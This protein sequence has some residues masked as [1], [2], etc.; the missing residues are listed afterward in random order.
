MIYV[1]NKQMRD[2]QFVH[3]WCLPKKPF[4]CYNGP[5]FSTIYCYGIQQIC[6]LQSHQILC[7]KNWHFGQPS[8][9]HPDCVR[10]SP[11]IPTSIYQIKAIQRQRPRN[12]S[13]SAC[14]L[15]C[16]CPWIAQSYRHSDVLVTSKVPHA[17]SKLV[18]HHPQRCTFLWSRHLVSHPEYCSLLSAWFPSVTKLL[19]AETKL[20]HWGTDTETPQLK[21]M[22]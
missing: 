19:P 13:A 6:Y 14:K 12:T 11:L 8:S 21:R 4:E 3:Q 5:S 10:P 20:R 9:Y 16:N 15:D 1:T 22:P 7:T 17:E 2:S 18:G